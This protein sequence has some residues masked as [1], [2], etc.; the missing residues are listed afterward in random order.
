[1]PLRITSGDAALP[2][3]SVPK[4]VPEIFAPVPVLPTVKPRSRLFVPS[5]MALTFVVVMVGL[6]PAVAGSASLPVGTV[7][8]PRFAS[9]LVAPCPMSFWL[10]R[11]VLPPVCAPEKRKMMSPA[12]SAAVCE[13]QEAVPPV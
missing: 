13:K 1:M 2:T 7:S 5:G 6:A 3:M 9:V 12:S 11:S 8:P 4:L 10:A